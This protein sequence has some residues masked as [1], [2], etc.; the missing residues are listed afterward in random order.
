LKKV[1][2]SHLF[3]VVI[4]LFSIKYF[5]SRAIVLGTASIP[6]GFAELF[7]IGI[8]AAIVVSVPKKMR[9]ITYCVLSIIYGTTLVF[10][11]IYY[12][13]FDRF[14][15]VF[16]LAEV[17]DAAA[18]KGVGGL[19]NLS[20]LLYYVDILV[21]F[22]SFILSSWV[23]KQF[24]GKPSIKRPIA[25]LLI[26]TTVVTSVTIFTTK[27]IAFAS[28]KEKVNKFG[29]AGYQTMSIMDA[30]KSD[31]FAKFK[32]APVKTAATIEE[33]KKSEFFG[34]AKGKNVI[35][36]QMEAFQ[37]FLI[38]QK[39]NGQE[40]TPNMNKLASET[41][42]FNHT[43]SQISQGNTSDAEF[44]SNTSIYPMANASVFKTEAD[45][46]YYGLPEVLKKNGYFTAT[47]HANVASFWN[48]E[49]MYPT[50]GFDKY[51]D[52]AS[53]EKKDIIG[54]GPSDEV[55]Y[56]K[57]LTELN[58]FKASGK[59]FYTQLIT[60][61]GHFPFEIPAIHKN[62]KIPGNYQACEAAKYLQAASYTDQALGT[63]MAG[64]KESGLYDDTLIVMYGDHFGLSTTK[65]ETTD[66]ALLKEVLGR[67]YDKVDMMNIP[68]LIKLPGEKVARTEPTVAGQIDVM[69]TIL[70]L[71]GIEDNK[72]VM[73]GKNLFF[74]KDNIIGMRY[75]MPTGSYADNTTLTSAD[76]T[77][78]NWDHTP[79]T[80]K[81]D[82]GK[83]SKILD[84][85]Q[86][87]D[88]YLKDLPVN[89]KK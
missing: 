2:G 39:I 74:G 62:L 56:K 5:L 49:N 12:N 76:G 89:A 67:D 18:V 7:I 65:L 64:L 79:A 15:T 84:V 21:L 51:Y 48:R 59:N 69:P 83:R 8:F 87:S 28:D 25:V 4:V 23:R 50:L 40:I 41:L 22:I 43:I 16:N 31:L 73:F 61:S 85:M 38:G 81:M 20:Y 78:L 11:G 82:P 66:K 26:L 13:Y 33:E 60:L 75:Y 24:H 72:T 14:P 37:N 32:K 34:V 63:F 88:A 17:G 29:F 86:T 47:F 70:A 53:F 71:L 27:D 3:L 9:P 55:Y 58:G 45:K 80:A 54:I 42:Y 46:D 68:L 19:F 1:K 36:I 10:M 57:V 35:V 30:I 52:A 44:L 77:V 6:G